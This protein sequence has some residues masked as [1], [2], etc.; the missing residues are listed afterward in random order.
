[1]TYKLGMCGC[2]CGV[3]FADFAASGLTAI[4]DC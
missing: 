4:D 1:M 3:R 2:D